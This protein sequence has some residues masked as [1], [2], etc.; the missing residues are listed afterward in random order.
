MSLT[1]HELV[2]QKFKVKKL[3]FV[4]FL[5]AG[6]KKEGVEKIIDSFLEWVDKTEEGKQRWESCSNHF[7]LFEMMEILRGCDSLTPFLIGQG[8]Q[9]LEIGH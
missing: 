7:T 4:K 5:F 1:L 9:N 6:T 3:I 2:V 8:I